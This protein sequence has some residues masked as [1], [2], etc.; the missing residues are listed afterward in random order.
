MLDGIAFGGVGDYSLL[1]GKKRGYLEHED[2]RNR[3][4]RAIGDIVW[5]CMARNRVTI[6]RI[7][8]PPN[9]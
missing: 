1:G 2:C 5:Y 3:N 4:D 7:R 8:R 9:S 6:Y